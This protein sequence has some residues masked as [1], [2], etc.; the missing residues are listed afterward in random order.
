ML[1]QSPYFTHALT[2]S[3]FQWVP[4]QKENIEA[5]GYKRLG[6]VD[7]DRNKLEE[8]YNLLEK[9]KAISCSFEDM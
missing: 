4:F 9:E 1:P 3:S 7:D 8:N 6:Y 5:F 2:Q